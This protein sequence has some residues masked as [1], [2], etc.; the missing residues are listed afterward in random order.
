[1]VTSHLVDQRPLVH[2]HPRVHAIVGVGVGVGHRVSSALLDDEMEGS[3][4]Q[5][6]EWSGYLL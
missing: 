2:F 6:L 5:K 1:M 4:W 3:V